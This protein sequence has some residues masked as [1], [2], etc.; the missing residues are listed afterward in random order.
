MYVKPGFPMIAMAARTP[1]FGATNITIGTSDDG[2]EVVVMILT[3]TS[4]TIHP[5]ANT[6]TPATS[7][8]LG[9]GA[10]VSCTAMI[11]ASSAL[12]SQEPRRP[13]GD[14]FAHLEAGRTA[15]LL[16]PRPSAGVIVAGRGSPG[17]RQLPT[18]NSQSRA[19]R[20]SWMKAVRHSLLAGLTRSHDWFLL[21]VRRWELEVI[22]RPPSG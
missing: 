8:P 15:T 12:L 7:R 14:P 17:N 21:G 6:A 3:I 9:G 5:S 20:E 18:R 4:V 19:G 13:C 16:Y 10:T 11:C 2:N 22:T 1:T